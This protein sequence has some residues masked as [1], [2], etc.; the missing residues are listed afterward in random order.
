M[1]AIDATTSV[2]DAVAELVRRAGADVGLL[3]AVA[4]DVRDRARHQPGQAADRAVAITRA[5]VETATSLARWDAP[6]RRRF[7]VA[8]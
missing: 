2:G 8:S 4:E 5:A 3:G 7:A 1:L 6:A